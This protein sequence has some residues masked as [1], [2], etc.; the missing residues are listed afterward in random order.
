[1][2]STELQPV[3]ILLVEDSPTDVLLAKEAL[4]DSRIANNLHTV[5]DGVAAMAFLRRE[6][7]YKNAPRP[8]LILLDLNLPKMD[9]REV[10]AEIKNDENLKRI[11]V[12]VLTTSK[13]EG[14]VMKAYGLHAN[15]YVVKP[16]NFE[17]FAKVVRSIESFWFS[18]VTLPTKLT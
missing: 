2:K 5:P 1:M 13:N 12:V 18:V 15:C 8:G 16:V 11:P 6:G 3:E 10:L 4:E 17:Q 14:D 9:G 7:K